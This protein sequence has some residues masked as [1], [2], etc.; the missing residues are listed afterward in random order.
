MTS[1]WQFLILTILSVTLITTGCS[2][3]TAAGPVVAV[4]PQNVA[5]GSA[6]Q[7]TA[8]GFAANVEVQ[9]GAGPQGADFAVEEAAQTD[10]DGE[11]ATKLNIPETAQ[12]DSQWVVVAR[13]TEAEGI[14][15][16]S[17]RFTIAAV[18]ATATSLP[19]PTKRPVPTDTLVPSAEVVISP[20]SGP[21]GTDVQLVASGLPANA[22]MQIGVGHADSEYDVVQSVSTDDSGRLE[23]RVAMPDYA[24][25]GERWMVVIDAVDSNVQAISNAFIVTGEA[26]NPTVAIAPLSGSPGTEVAV[27]AT[28]FPPS[29]ALEIRAGP[30]D[31][32]Y[33]VI[34]TGQSDANGA[35]NTRVSMPEYA[36]P[37]EEWVIVVSTADH[38][39]QAVSE[40]FMVTGEANPPTV[41]ISPLSGP[42]DTQVQVTASGFPPNTEVQVGAGRQGSEF[43]VTKRVDTDAQ[44]RILTSIT[45]PD[46]AEPGDPWGVVVRVVA[47][48]GARALSGTFQVTQPE[49]L[50]KRTNIY[51]IAVGDEGASGEEIGCGDSAVPVEVPIEPTIAPLTAGLE[52]LLAIESRDYGQSGLYNALYRSDLTVESVVIRDREAVIRLNG[53]LEIGGTC[54][55]PRVRAQLEETALQFSTVDSVSVSVN[56][57]PLDTYLDAQ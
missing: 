24:E 23:M 33:D 16:S 57:D 30:V 2:T 55:A 42:P 41:S 5:P 34:T 28:G 25:P 40:P 6:V 7:V 1:K 3:F 38:A 39:T 47:Q 8:D 29:A 32:E 19:Q 12:P 53:T 11:L 46:F 26:R 56:G 20:V 13:E 49:N 54:D 31:S 36:D 15:A 4:A 35:F 50:F 21:P 48:G 52:A 37:G 17:D 22:A 27:T 18:S 9:V 51:L 14:E 45:I 43:G 10:D 44:G